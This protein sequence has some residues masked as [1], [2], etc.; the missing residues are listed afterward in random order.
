VSTSRLFF[1]RL[2]EYQAIRLVLLLGLLHG[3][4]YIF[5]MPPWQHYDEPG[6][7][8]YAWL[9]ANREGI[10][11]KGDFD[12]GVR[13][14]IAASM[15]EHGFFKELS[16]YPDLLSPVEPIWIGISQ[17]GDVPLYYALVSLPLR[18][19]RGTDVT[20][21]LYVGRF[22]SLSLLLI[23]IAAAYAA[24]REIA[25]PNHPL[26]IFIPLS[27]AL[28]PGF[29]DLMTAV[30]ND[31]GAVAVFTVFLW[32]GVRMLARGLSAGRVFGLAAAAAAC[33]LTKSTAAMALP[34]G[35]LV[36][37]LSF[38]RTFRPTR[39]PSP[40]FPFIILP[41]SVFLISLAVSLFGWGGARSWASQGIAY[42][43]SPIESAQ[44]PQLGKKAFRL[45]PNREFPYA[46][47]VQPTEPSL[48]SSIRGQ[49]V[50]LGAWIWADG[51]EGEPIMARTPTLEVDG[52]WHNAPVEITTEPAFYATS[53]QV[54]EDAAR[55][56]LLLVPWI[57]SPVPPEGVYY[58]GI[59]LAVGNFPI[60]EV[61]TYSKVGAQ[62]GIWADIPFTNLVKNPS[63]EQTRLQ[64]RP[65]VSALLAK[66]LSAD[67]SLI[68][69]SLDDL[70][71]SSFY[72]RETFSYLIQTFW[73]RFGWGHVV[74][75]LRGLRP[76]W[77]LTFF[78]LIGVAASIG[79]AAT[80]RRDIPW[81]GVIFLSLAMVLVWSMTAFRGLHSLIGTLFIPSAR[82][83]FPAILPTVLAIFPGWYAVWQ[84]SSAWANR[85]RPSL[86]LRDAGGWALFGLFF[87]ALNLT[88]LW[89]I[90]RYYYR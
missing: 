76:Y 51:V 84:W 55:I 90:F 63:A 65:P 1:Y 11:Q 72:Y 4:L 23:T 69:L 52:R 75:E 89:S 38:L 40:G 8:E 24:M 56:N 67:P 21:Q 19:L 41:V 29:I 32:A 15:I 53:I 13:R 30:N 80:K 46:S 27:L 50:S 42:Q 17:V 58:D 77:F 34:L 20:F 78:S 57:D 64:F 82:Y 86:R 39:S 36:L 47:L 9:M 79:W 37:F 49:T 22:L 85:R 68:F 44:H 10:P 3:L 14:E 18:V 7:F 66:I 45:Q 60:Q 43:V 48:L 74:M 61:P 5:L 73:G 28:L 31:V 62:E 26:R 83:A 88:A 25:P 59:T 2:Q 71:L 87:L 54:P 81:E 70:R 35:V 16:I 6:H 33:L 12:Q